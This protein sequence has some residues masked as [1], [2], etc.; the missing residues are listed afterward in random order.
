MAKT[1]FRMGQKVRDKITGFE[2]IIVG[3]H[4]WITG[5]DQYT[6]QPIKEEN[7]TEYPKSETFDDGRLEKMVGKVTPKKVQSKKG[8]C[9]YTAPTK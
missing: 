8:G 1:K 2:G 4:K 5:C 9:D 7:K 6:V 3:V